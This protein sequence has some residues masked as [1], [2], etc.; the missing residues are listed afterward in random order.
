[1]ATFA[2]AGT[3]NRLRRR[4][5]GAPGRQQPRAKT[6]MRQFVFAALL[7]TAAM[8]APVALVHADDDA[9][10]TDQAAIAIANKVQALYDQ[11]KTFQADVKQEYLIKIH[12]DNPKKTQG[13][14][15]F[16]KPGRM[17]WKY[18]QPNGNRVVSDGHILKVYEQ[19]NQQMFE[20]PVDKSQYPA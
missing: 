1:I 20:Q 11:T 10:A 17:S 16:E 2:S 7:V 8:G 18:D 5:T 19:E 13:H 14:V 9:P 12:P 3:S 6:T 4:P 15:V